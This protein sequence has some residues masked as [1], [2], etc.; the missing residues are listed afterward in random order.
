MNLRTE[1]ICILQMKI[2]NDAVGHNLGGEHPF[3]DTELVQVGQIG[4][5]MDYGLCAD[6][7]LCR[8]ARLLLPVSNQHT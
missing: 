5:I 2:P 3:Y 8:F 1:P 6:D 4:G 7:E